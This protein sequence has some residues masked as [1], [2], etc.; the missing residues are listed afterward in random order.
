MANYDI[1]NS[2]K[3]IG[4]KKERIKIMK[5]NSIQKTDKK[6]SIT[7]PEELLPFLLGN[8]KKESRNNVKSLLRHKEV[9]VDGICVTR[10]DYK[11]NPGQRVIIKYSIIRDNGGKKALDIIYED[12]DII[13]INKPAGL[14]SIS[15][16]KEKEHTAY[17]MLMD[18]VRED[19]PG[20]RIFIVHRLDRDTSGLLLFAKNEQT[21]FALQDNWADILLNRGY[22][23]VVEGCPKE[24][25]GTVKSWLRETKTHLMY[26]S[27]TKDDGQEAITNYRVV[28]SSGKYSVLD[29]RIETGRKNQIRV[30]M[31]DIGHCIVG[32]RQ[33]GSGKSTQKRLFLHAHLLELKHPV[34]G[35]VLRFETEIPKQFISIL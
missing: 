11:L 31:K 8:L 2:G 32:D 25:N 12:Q 34:S 22:T 21:K 23:A 14:L 20:S 24:R 30:H 19:D 18:Y 29:I 4:L 16:E 5:K 15:S 35:N 7:E 9:F 10:H 17:R 26:S 6:I 27:H 1:I 28:K 13:V 3:Q 33:Y